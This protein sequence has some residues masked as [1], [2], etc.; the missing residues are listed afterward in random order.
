VRDKLRLDR[1]V[2]E[3]ESV[4][5]EFQQRGLMFLDGSLAVALALPAVGS[6]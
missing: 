1:P 3:I 6:R 5:R 4:F 2:G